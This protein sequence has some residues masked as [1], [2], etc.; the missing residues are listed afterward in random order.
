KAHKCAYV[1]HIDRRGLVLHRSVQNYS[2]P[3][4]LGL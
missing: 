1:A 2:K 3:L 4:F